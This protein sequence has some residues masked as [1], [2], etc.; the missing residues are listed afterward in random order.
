MRTAIHNRIVKK[1]VTAAALF[2]EYN[3]NRDCVQGRAISAAA[4]GGKQTRCLS[5]NN[6]VVAW[7]HLEGTKRAQPNKCYNFAVFQ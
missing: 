2:V 7:R 1:I 3:H 4:P 5:C 6:P